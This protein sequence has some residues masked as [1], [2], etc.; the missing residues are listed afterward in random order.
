MYFRLDFDFVYRPPPCLVSGPPKLARV[1]AAR[2][3]L[4]GVSP[5]VDF[6]LD[7][8]SLDEVSLDEVSVN[9][10]GSSDSPL[11]VSLTG[12]FTMGDNSS[13]GVG[14]FCDDDVPM[15][16]M[17]GCLTGCPSALTGCLSAM[18]AGPFL[19]PHVTKYAYK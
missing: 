7:E 14:K 3:T 9:T 13:C 12:A 5:V 15:S 2:L 10:S 1:L 11:C 6:S 4:D 19:H 16:S 18:P 8:V 17:A